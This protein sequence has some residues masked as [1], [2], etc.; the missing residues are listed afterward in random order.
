MRK[1]KGKAKY[2]LALLALLA[3]LALVPV[4][5]EVE[6]K[7]TRVLKLADSYTTCCQIL[8]DEKVQKQ[9][10]ESG[11]LE[12]STDD[13]EAI[14]SIEVGLFSRGA[15]INPFTGTYSRTEDFQVLCDTEI[16]EVELD[17]RQDTKFTMKELEVLTYTLSGDSVVK[18]YRHAM[19][20]NPDQDVT[21][22]IL[23]LEVRI[24]VPV[25]WLFR[26]VARS[27]LTKSVDLQLDHFAAELKATIN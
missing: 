4:P 15:T 12:T 9:L 20:L 22:V 11:G 13:A 25:P 17:L 19:K 10:M 24:Q 7:T 26:S 18:N 8:S 23:E 6:A 21:V 1:L 2:I 27:R 16:G 14:P 3:I 5:F